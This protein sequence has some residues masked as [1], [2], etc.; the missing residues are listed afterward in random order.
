[1]FVFL[2]TER[3]HSST[4]RE[5]DIKISLN[6]FKRRNKI[7]IYNNGQC[8]ISICFYLF[9]SCLN[10][11][12]MSMLLQIELFEDLKIFWKLTILFTQ[13][14]PYQKPQQAFVILVNISPA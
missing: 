3:N 14:K 11:E 13:R 10:I 12:M 5:E 2:I 9:Y 7:A 6:N 4:L 8:I 1:M